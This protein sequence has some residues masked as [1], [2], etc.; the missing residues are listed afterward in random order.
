M[1]LIITHISN[2][3]FKVEMSNGDVK[4]A[5]ENLRGMIRYTYFEDFTLPPEGWSVS[6]K[7]LI[8]DYFPKVMKDIK[9]GKIKP[10]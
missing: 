5:G 4:N 3:N 7:K 10:E 6:Q 1:D 8:E 9:D 2:G